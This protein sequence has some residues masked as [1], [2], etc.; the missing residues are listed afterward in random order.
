MQ[1]QCKLLTGL[2]P[3]TLGHFL[4]GKGISHIKQVR[5][6]LPTSADNATLLALAVERRPC[7]NRSVSPGRLAHSSKPAAACGR[8]TGRTDGQTHY[9]KGQTDRRTDGWT[10]GSFID[11]ARTL[12]EKRQ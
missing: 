2:I 3:A 12:C 6:Q 9:T 10:P 1:M 5:V 7:S 4:L 8:M 11:P